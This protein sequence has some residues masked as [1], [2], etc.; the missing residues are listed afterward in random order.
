MALCFEEI[1]LA[2]LYASYSVLTIIFDIIL[3]INIR[4]C[5]FMR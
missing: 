1:A 2:E 3:S 4:D 5:S